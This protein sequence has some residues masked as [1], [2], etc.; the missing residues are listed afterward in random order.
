MF[1]SIRLYN[2]RKKI[3]LIFMLFILSVSLI[4]CS[5]PVEPAASSNLLLNPSFSINGKPSLDNWNIMNASL[6]NL[7]SDFPPFLWGNVKWC[8][9]AHTLEGQNTNFIALGMVSQNVKLL[10]G[11]HIYTLSFWAKNDS[12]NPGGAEIHLPVADAW[13]YDKGVSV[14]SSLWSKYFLVDTLSSDQF[15]SVEIMLIGGPTLGKKGNTLFGPC[16][17]T[18]N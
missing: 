2:F 16:R 4:Q 10:S 17:L 15:S 11:K 13:K 6:V 3:G 8:V 14:S 9:A 18:A 7:T 12:I 5:N 1:A